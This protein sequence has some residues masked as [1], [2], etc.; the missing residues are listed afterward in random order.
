LSEA[1]ALG[2]ECAEVIV[3]TG[4]STT[5]IAS[6]AVAALL[7]V[8][9][10]LSGMGPMGEHRD[11]DGYYMSDPLPVDRASHA[12]V[13]GDT[14]L[15]RGR[16]E[17]LTEGS[18]VLGF[19]D[20]PDDVRMQAIASGTNALF[21]GIAPTSAVDDY[22]EGVAHDEITDWNADL[23]SIDE[24]EYTTHPGA[25]PPDRPGSETFWEISA[26]GTGQQTLDWTIESGEWTAVIMRADAS[27]GVAGE[28]AFGAA[29]ADDI[30]ALA[31]TSLAFGAGALLVGGLLLYIGVSGR[32]R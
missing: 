24:V 5:A 20:Q 11:A 23:A 26:E 10:I 1:T 19:V 2:T 29:P 3:M 32:D 8:V 15:L 6:S 14:N 22:L 7:G 31:R 21:L 17:T 18:V 13:S 9:L 27:A 4:R 12:I 25:A 30:E 16:W 28:L